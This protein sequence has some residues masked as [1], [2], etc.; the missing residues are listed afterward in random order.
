MTVLQNL[1]DIRRHSGPRRTRGIPD[2]RL[3]TLADEYPDLVAA[4]D[5]ALALHQRL[6]QTDPEL[7]AM[8]EADL[9]EQVQAGYTN[10]YEPPAVQ[11]Y[12]GLAARGPWLVTLH[13][14]V[15]H[16][17][18]GYGMLG[19][20]H[21]PEFVLEA[22]R[23]PQ[24]MANVMTPSLSQLRL[25]RRLRAELG[26]T[27]DGGC[28]FSRFICLNSGSEA[29]T[30]AT[31]LADINAA[32]QTGGGSA[33]RNRRIR[34]LSI[35]GSFHGRTFCPARISDSCRKAYEENLASFRD[36]SDLI[37]VPQNDVAA[38]EAA[39]AQADRDQVFIDAV[40]MEPVQGEGAPGRAITRE[41]Y[42]AAVRLAHKHGSLV[43]VDSIQ[44]GLRA[45][46]VLSIV[47]Y[48]GFQDCTPPDIETWS[49]ALNAGQFPLSVVGLSERAANLYVHGVYGNTMT[50]NPR[51]LDVACAVLDHVTPEMRANVRERGQQFLA[52][53]E[54][55]RDEFPGMITEIRGTGLL[56]CAEL[57]PSIPC[58]GFGGA[59]ERCRLAGLGVIHGGRNA[60]RFTP[61]FSITEGEVRLVMDLLREVFTE[62]QATRAA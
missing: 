10:F 60:L 31:R 61:R 24:V 56:F 11:P 54:G 41:F 2:E 50:T 62:L 1:D 42:D 36:H 43:V 9:C 57:D 53:L 18:G 3:V 25:D 51:A 34:H 40:Y 44:A 22:L 5:E 46:G 39:F 21:N 52:E 20:G 8:P 4:V 47:D 19:H 49:K 14:A 48:P 37:T 26:H 29:M 35:E 12:V 7:L 23:R 59:E 30:M 58:V 32:R 15:I 55:L 16:D 27:R 13:G 17:N 6:R 38:L 45:H 28:P 33:M